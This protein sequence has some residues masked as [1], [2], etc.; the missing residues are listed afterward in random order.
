MGDSLYYF[1]MKASCAVIALFG[2]LIALFPSKFLKPSL[3]EKQNGKLLGRLLGA[4]CA[5]GGVVAIV[6]QYTLLV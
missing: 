3:L 1:L 6:L 5:V 4:I 2:L